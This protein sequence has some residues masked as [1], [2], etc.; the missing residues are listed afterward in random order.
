MHYFN[1]C[2][3]DQHPTS[4]PILSFHHI[5][6][7]SQIKSN[8]STKV[9]VWFVP[10][11]QSSSCERRR[12][13]SSRAYILYYIIHRRERT[14]WR[15]QRC[16]SIRYLTTNI[17]TNEYFLLSIN[18]YTHCLNSAEFTTSYTCIHIIHTPW[19]HQSV[20]RERN[21]SP[22]DAHT[23]L[24]FSFNTLPTRDVISYIYS[25]VSHIYVHTY[26]YNIGRVDSRRYELI[27][28]WRVSAHLRPVLGRTRLAKVNLSALTCQ[29]VVINPFSP[30]PRDRQR[31]HQW[32]HCHS[33]TVRDVPWDNSLFAH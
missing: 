17:S 26:I 20:P 31:S 23:I 27:T 18:K 32:H 13:M 5:K 16:V 33:W 2:K 29:W 11:F 24:L 19:E 30:T 1:S 3:N 14:S 9:I 22:P 25:F 21:M 4:I 7:T 28:F 6:K 12:L 10:V 15:K 8:K